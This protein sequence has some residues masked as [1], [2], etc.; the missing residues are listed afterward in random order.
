[1]IPANQRTG[2]VNKRRRTG[3]V[4]MWED[5][6]VEGCG[7]HWRDVRAQCADSSD[8]NLISH[9]AIS[10]LTY[11]YKL[12]HAPALLAA[13]QKI[14]SPPTSRGHVLLQ[15]VDQP[16]VALMSEDV[17]AGPGL[18]IVGDCLSLANVLNGESVLL[19]SGLAPL[20]TRVTDN[21]ITLFKYLNQYAHT[22]TFITWRPRQLNQM[23]DSAANQCMD[24]NT[25]HVKWNLPLPSLAKLQTLRVIAFSDGG[26]SKDDRRAATG[27]FILALD[28]LEAWILGSGGT[29]V[30]S[31]GFGSFAIEAFALE[32]L[33]TNLLYLCNNHGVSDN[34]WK[35]ESTPYVQ[36]RLTKVSRV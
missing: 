27:W 34:S 29:V 15:E 36:E 31:N 24:S 9:S 21:L 7:I 5:V 18:T 16:I 28:G 2:G 22:N 23:A 20:C 30:Q 25:N 11:K 14:S 17:A 1:M 4:R 26:L 8:W 32:D 10:Q 33:I 12:P 19:S 6:L 13:S 3:P 35:I